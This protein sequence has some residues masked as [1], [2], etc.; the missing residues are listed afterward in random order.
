MTPT[1]W[2]RMLVADARAQRLTERCAEHSIDVLWVRE[3]NM[4]SP[5]LEELLRNTVLQVRIAVIASVSAAIAQRVGV[6]G[7]HLADNSERASGVVAARQSGLAVGGSAH[8][9]A[10]VAALRDLGVDWI[11]F[12]PVRATPKGG[13]LLPGCGFDALRAAA[14]AAGPVPLI[15]IGGLGPQDTA[16]LRAC[17]ASG[18]AG[19]RC[20]G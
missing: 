8:A 10:G 17:G 7:V 9:L 18:L 12:G 13:V 2:G 14:H 11:V 16:M 15:A 3:K 1:N 19:I 4:A 6:H 20:F 5:A